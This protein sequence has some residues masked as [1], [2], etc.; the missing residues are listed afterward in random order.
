MLACIGPILLVLLLSFTSWRGYGALKPVFRSPKSSFTSGEVD[1]KELEEGVVKIVSKCWGKTSQRGGWVRHSHLLTPHHLIRRAFISA[2]TPLRNSP[3][4][5]TSPYKITTQRQSVELLTLEEDWGLVIFYPEKTRGWIPIKFLQSDP[6]DLGFA[7]T[8][9]K[10]HI[11][12]DIKNKDPILKLPPHTRLTILSMI[13]NQFKI[14]YGQFVGYVHLTDTLNKILLNKQNKRNKQ[15][16]SSR[17]TAHSSQ[18]NQPF[19]F[20][21]KETYIHPTP[22]SAKKFRNKISPLEPILL[23]RTLC[24]KW[25][26]SKVKSH[27]HTGDFLW[28]KVSNWNFNNKTQNINE[29]P[30]SNNYQNRGVQNKGRQFQ[31]GQTGQTG[32]IEQKNKTLNQ[33]K[34]TQD[35]FKRKIFSMAV[36]PQNPRLSFVSANGIF[37]TLDGE[38]WKKISF[39]KDH[40]HPIAIS[41]TG[42]I[43]VGPYISQDDGKTFHPFLRWDKVAWA[44]HHKKNM[45]HESLSLQKIKLLDD[46]GKKISITVKAKD[47]TYSFLS[48]NHGQTWAITR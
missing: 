22:N 35:I 42:D 23:E 29:D 40:N 44:I 39:F 28:W 7:Y 5:N 9:Q 45:T 48:K 6:T 47:K 16:K 20:S 24:Q 43:F 41:K 31:T 18:S 13:G 21:K 10:T 8:K 36:H 1:L 37:S 19:F 30:L 46:V 12:R 14:K 11:Y 2:K 33:L 17:S 34:T 4:W 27:H 26:L 3:H 32:Q 15:N 25:G 38:T